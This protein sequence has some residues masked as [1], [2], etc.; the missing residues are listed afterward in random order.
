MPCP[1]CSPDND[2]DHPPD[3]DEVFRSVLH[4]VGKKVN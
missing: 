2:W 1:K 3:F 4:V